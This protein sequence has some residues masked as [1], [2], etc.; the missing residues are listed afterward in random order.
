VQPEHGKLLHTF[1]SK[2]FR[3]TIGRS[4]R[5]GRLQRREKPSLV[6]IVATQGCRSFGRRLALGLFTRCI[7]VGKTPEISSEDRAILAMA[8]FV[9]F[10]SLFDGTHS[11]PLFHN[12][13]SASPVRVMAAKPQLA[14]RWRAGLSECTLRL[15]AE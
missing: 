3:E 7:V 8:G 2:L 4:R 12:I 1:V 15:R 13:V 11:T 14:Y 6:A 5:I 9:C 10:I